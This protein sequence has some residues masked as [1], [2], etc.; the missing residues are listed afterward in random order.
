MINID[1]LKEYIIKP[2]LSHLKLYSLDA[3]ELLLFTAAA[4]SKG[5]TYIHQI[6]GPALGIY[7]CEPATHDDIWKNYLRYRIDLVNILYSK[8][9]VT[10]PPIASRL[11]YDMQYATAMC[12]LHFLRVKEPLPSFEDV[13]AMYKYYKKH[14]NTNKGKATKE[15]S[16]KAYEAF[17][18]S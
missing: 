4:E 11:I 9:N 14:Y 13:E 18:K 12:R 8:L 10:T 5:G 15:K 16:I 7:Q 2:T 6:N 17:L 3:V 1:Q